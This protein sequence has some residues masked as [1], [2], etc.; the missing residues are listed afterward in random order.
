MEMVYKSF[1]AV[2]SSHIRRRRV[3]AASRISSTTQM[4]PALCRF[5]HLTENPSMLLSVANHFYRD[6]Q[7]EWVCLKLDPDKIQ[8][9]VI[10]VRL[11]DWATVY[12]IRSHR[13]ADSLTADQ[14]QSIGDS[15]ITLEGEIRGGRC[16]GE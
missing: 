2:H 8:D 4:I 16:S 1:K 3:Q 14:L 10:R 6:V 7:G 15:G 9:E 13:S 12:P 11:R 5:T